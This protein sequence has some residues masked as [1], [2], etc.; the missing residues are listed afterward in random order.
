MIIVIIVIIVIVAEG[1]ACPQAG[2][3]MT[4]QHLLVDLDLDLDPV[5]RV[6]PTD[7]SHNAAAKYQG[8]RGARAKGT[9]RR[10]AKRPEEKRQAQEHRQEHHSQEHAQGHEKRGS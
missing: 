8:R 9:Q 6:P 1:T 3:P 2:H 10:Q 7:N 4:A 5:L